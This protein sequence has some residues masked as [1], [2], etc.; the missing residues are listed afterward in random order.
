MVKRLRRVV[1]WL[2]PNRTRIIFALLALTGLI[3]LILNAVNTKEHPADWVPVAQSAL[4]VAFLVGAA[5]TVVTRF[6]PDT[7]RQA[8]LIIGPAL[9]AISLGVL[10]PSLILFFVPVGLGWM[11]IAPI[12]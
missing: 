6:G 1:D 12:A 9:V 3:S 10:F 11:I 8:V 4:L 2:G 7:R 5:I